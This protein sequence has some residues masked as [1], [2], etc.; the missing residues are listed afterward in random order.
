MTVEIIVVSLIAS[1]IFGVLAG[2]Y[3]RLLIALSRKGS[4][5]LRIKEILLT[6]R[7]EAKQILEAAKLEADTLIISEKQAIKDKEEKLSRQ[8]ERLVKKEETL[9]KR[10]ADFEAEIVELKNKVVEIKHIKDKADAL[11]EERREHL[12]AAASLSAAEAKD[13]L[14]KDIENQYAEDLVVRI[15]KLEHSNEDKIEAKAKTILTDAIQRLGSSVYADLMSTAVSIPS[16]EIKGK[17]IGKEGRNIKAFERITGV[18]VLIDDTPNLITLSSFNPLRRHIAKLALELLIADGRIQPARIEELHEKAKNEINRTIKE[19]GEQAVYEC[20]VFNLDPKLV[21]IIGRLHF[22]TSYGQ[23]VLQHSL[24]VAH[25]AGM[26]AQEVGANV[27]VAKAGGLLHDIGKALD[28]E[29]QGTHVEIGRRILQKFSVSEDIIKAMQAHH[30]DYPHETLES[31]IVQVADALSGSRP[32]ARKDSMEMYLERLSDLEN[33]AN[34]IQGV[35]KSYVLSAGREI[36]VFVKSD[37]ITD[38]DAKHIARTIAEK[39]EQELNYPGEIK[40]TVIRETRII[41]F[42]R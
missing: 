21:S 32:G 23:N 30:G 41:D 14:I 15:Q 22:R 11:L 39:I 7:E 33:V 12:E 36:R 25:L 18:E 26:I 40:V 3:L 2:Y 17:I 27:Q 35:E 31:V 38:L 1:G 20:G 29:V 4:A 37:A 5:E 10:Q 13:L 8:E 42:A 16:E 6:A 34:K 24:E 9:E 19:K 28:H